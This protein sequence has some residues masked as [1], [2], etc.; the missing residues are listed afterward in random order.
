MPAGAVVQ[1]G[2]MEL[3]FVAKDGRAQL[4]LVKTGKRVGEEV[5][6]ASGVSAGEQVVSANA[7]SL[8]DGQPII[9]K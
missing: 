8:A 1:R 3:L 6:V 4:R 9:V 7:A 5:E 2:Q